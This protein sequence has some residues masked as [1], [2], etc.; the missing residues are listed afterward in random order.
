MSDRLIA[1][2]ELVDLCLYQLDEYERVLEESGGVVVMHSV[3]ELTRLRGTLL[4]LRQLIGG[5]QE[6]DRLEGM[7]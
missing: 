1:V 2:Y 3:F 5:Y 7:A 4:V 6:D